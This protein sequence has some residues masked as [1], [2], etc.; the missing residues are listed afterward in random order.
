MRR[1]WSTAPRRECAA[2]TAGTAGAAAEVYNVG[3]VLRFVVASADGPGPG[4]T[5][6]DQVG[7]GE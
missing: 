7:D 6:P 1:M 4:Y 2:G 5:A 3:G